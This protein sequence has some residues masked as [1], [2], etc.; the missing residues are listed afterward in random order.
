MGNLCFSTSS[1][2]FVNNTILDS[3]ADFIRPNVGQGIINAT[4]SWTPGHFSPEAPVFQLTSNLQHDS[5]N[6]DNVK[7]PEV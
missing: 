1:S 3:C 6:V 4:Y 2:L 5:T 7:T